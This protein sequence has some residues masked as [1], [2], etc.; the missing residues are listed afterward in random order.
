MTQYSTDITVE[1]GADFLA[2]RRVGLRYSCV[3]S[4]EKVAEGEE[5]GGGDTAGTFA[6]LLADPSVQAALWGTGIGGGIGLLAGLRRKKERRNLLRD[7]LTGA[8][9]GGIGLGGLSLASRSLQGQ[10]SDEVSPK[11]IGLPGP[12]IKEQAAWRENLKAQGLEPDEID[13]LLQQRLET[14]IAEAEKTSEGSGLGAATEWIQGQERTGDAFNY[15]KLLSTIGTS[16]AIAGRGWGR[17]GGQIGGQIASGVGLADDTEGAAELGSSIGGPAGMVGGGGYAAGVLGNMYGKDKA[18][19]IDI[20]NSRIDAI[21]EGLFGDTSWDKKPHGG[22][23]GKLKQPAEQLNALFNSHVAKPLAAHPTV[24]ATI[25]EGFHGGDAN[26]RTLLNRMFL[27]TPD[28]SPGSQ[29]GKKALTDFLRAVKQAERLHIKNLPVGADPTTFGN[30]LTPDRQ[31]GHI[32]GAWQQGKLPFVK[33][34]GGM[35]PLTRVNPP[36][37][38]RLPLTARYW[39][40][41]GWKGK[42]KGPLAGLAFLGGGVALDTFYNQDAGAQKNEDVYKQTLEA[43]AKPE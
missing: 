11:N 28:A 22:K 1:Q 5:E 4:L 43:F 15:S 35:N 37:N 42:V 9:A 23:P 8:L 29:A 27:E 14:L 24:L 39:G 34:F 3:P 26:S 12:T 40:G 17:F 33:G 21:G 31:L 2:R 16:P 38:P 18:H 13:A 19:R 6:A 25:R 30:I 7:A 20:T 41:K 10:F 32:A 36:L